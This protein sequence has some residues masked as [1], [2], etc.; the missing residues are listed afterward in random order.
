MADPDQYEQCAQIVEG[1]SEGETDDRVLAL[2]DWIA[3]G[4]REQA[5]DVSVLH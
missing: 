3:K 4:L 5:K 2:L 1:W